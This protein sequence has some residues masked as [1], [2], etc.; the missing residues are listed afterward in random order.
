MAKVLII[1]SGGREHALAVN[2]I[3]SN[4][5]VHVYVAPGNGGTMNCSNNISNICIDTN[6]FNNLSTWCLENHINLVVVGPENPLANGITDH[7][8]KSGVNCFGPCVQ[9]ARLEA[10]K[11][12]A[13]DFMDR[14]KIPT[15]RWKSFSNAD[16][17]CNHI[18]CA[19][20]PALVV[21]ASGLAAGKGVIVAETREEACQ[22][23]K[24]ILQDKKFGSA[25][26]TVV[27]EERLEGEEISV[28][29]FTDGKTYA[30]FPPAQDHKRLCDGD[31]GPNTG[32]MGA[33]C[34]CPH[35]PRAELLEIEKNVVQA[36]I[37]GMNKD[38]NKYVGVLYAGI[39]RTKNGPK[40]LE[41]NCRFGD[42]ETQVLMP[43]LSSD[44]YE[45]MTHCINGTLE[46]NKPTF[47][48]DR[49][50][51]GVVLVSGGYPTSFQKGFEISGFDELLKGGQNILLYHGATTV[52]GTG[53]FVTS[54]GRVL[55]VVAVD[56]DL[57]ATIKTSQ[58]MAGRIRF[59]NSFFRKDIGHHALKFSQLSY[60]DAG[61]DIM[62]GD[63]LVRAIAPMAASTSRSGCQVE[64]GMFGGMFDLKAA[65]YREPL[66]VSGTD[67]VGTKL[68]I[69]KICNKH[70][71]VGIDLVAM[72]VNDVLAHGA[73]PLFFL[74]YFACGKLDVELAKSVIS[75]ITEGCKL[76]GC[77]LIGGE[78][79]EMPGMYES[80]D[81]DLAGFTVGAV[82]RHHT[83]P[84]IGD[85]TPDDVIIGVASSGLHSNGFSLVRK[86]MSLQGIDYDMEYPFTEGK[87]IGDVLL[88]PTK[89]YSKSLLPVLRSGLVKAYAHITGGGLF[90]NIPRV[91]PKCFGV[92]IDA[93]SWQIPPLFGWLMKK[94][95][96]S[97]G[98][99]ARTFNCGIGAV[100]IC[101]KH[102]AN[103]VVSQ[104]KE[105][106]EKAWVIG[107]VF[108]NPAD[109]EQVCIANLEKEM[110][111]HCPV[112]SNSCMPSQNP[113]P[114][115]KVKVGVLISGS[116][117]NLQALI[118]HT[119]NPQ[120]DSVAEIV[121]VI[122]NRA[123]AKGLKRAQDASIPTKV[124]SHKDFKSRL[125]FDLSVDA[126]LRKSGVQLICLAGFMRILS[127][128]FTRKWTG[129]LINVHPS[130]LP[131]FK[132]HN[133]H[134][135][136]LE[137]GV[138]I[139]GCT[140]HFVT[141]E[142]D[143]GAIIVQEAAPVEPDDDIHSLQERVKTKEHIA[144][145]KALELLASGKV[146][147]DSKNN[148]VIWC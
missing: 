97:P 133:A 70:D 148:R 93:A 144:Y 23:V 106:G 136:V 1:G 130:L 90:E 77:A 111:R 50:A 117:T 7:L 18:N 83:L 146:K 132:G 33:Y 62:A 105:S 5:V 78:T 48:E 28:L 2:L 14:Y 120:L 11:A 61:V 51:V 107:K 94:G 103:Q 73:E 67:G 31:K 104:V 124:I 92:R 55:T 64:L 109:G 141:D 95:N 30:C 36:T 22:A 86:I 80:G 85:I 52:D 116:G 47:Y 137:A 45:T 25:G 38:G 19:D 65:G 21:K 114:R 129:S 96:I 87:T 60:K 98:E 135:M 24:L 27:I 125:D 91:L 140:V 99:M 123:D 44:L 57:T 32:G 49:F 37:D 110:G 54:G 34:P 121:L 122:S 115:N 131:S 82:E 147:F 20:Y 118:D 76:A 16:E 29:A 71:T 74:D 84:R 112:S 59:K 40:V 88:I 10:S 145:P 17:A 26:D 128:E 39:M 102:E 81:Y 9:A 143:A 134:K 42:P 35:V 142:V 43:M 12:F 3:K 41:F 66:L 119:K 56:N 15:A 4:R 101:P 127:G 69:A 79:A 113:T 63:N 72:C 6:D 58:T 138:R 75:G 89:I 53:K 68:K 100:L 8:L 13:K 126:A 108:E 139:T 46:S